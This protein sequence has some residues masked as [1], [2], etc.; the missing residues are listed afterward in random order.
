MDKN[1]CLCSQ[2]MEKMTGP[3]IHVGTIENP[4]HNLIVFKVTLSKDIAR[5]F[6]EDQLFVEY[7]IP[8]S[9]LPKSI[10]IIPL[11]SLICPI[12][13]ATGAD[14]WL[15][16]LDQSF[17]DVLPKIRDGFRAMY[18][19]M[20][21]HGNVAPK[22]VKSNTSPVGNAKSATLFSG[23]LDSVVTYLRKR[24]E[25]PYLISIWGADV[26]LDQ[27]ATWNNVCRAI[28]EFRAQSGAGWFSVKSNFRK[29]INEPAL[30]IYFG[31]KVN[32]WWGGVEHGLILTGLC[33]PLAHSLGIG[34][35]YIPSSHSAGTPW[36]K[37]G[38][39]PEIDNLIRWADTSVE[40]EAY[41]LD[42]QDKTAFFADA[43]RN[44]GRNY[45]LRVC[46]VS[47]Q[48][49][50]DSKQSS[51]SLNCSV[52][53][54]CCRTIIGLLL[55][56]LRPENHG[57]DFGPDTLP[58]I[59]RKLEAGAWGRFNIWGEYIKRRIPERIEMVDREYQDFFMW[60]LRFD[61]GKHIAESGK[62][63]ETQ[64]VINRIFAEILPEEMIISYKMTKLRLRQ[65]LKKL[66]R[67]A[68]SLWGQS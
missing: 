12:A 57:F 44:D 53:E 24:K 54:K 32:G 64:H 60:L 62:N 65:R 61:I 9:E 33:A 39:T 5:F 30:D 15:D 58:G 16:E 2:G 10:Q 1:S 59:K 7:S 42:R 17:H 43:V 67:Q 48:G 21:W 37:W 41:E 49:F 6:L 47:P 26:A 29:F 25:Q 3:A 23:G 51:E 11:L 56:G 14:I 45:K 35:L 66:R 40:H 50:R 13:W 19:Q 28:E 27:P 46:W 36:I 34:R 18:P 63:R 20:G 22:R 38:S 4:A 8:V 55:E 68:K 52:C 31:D